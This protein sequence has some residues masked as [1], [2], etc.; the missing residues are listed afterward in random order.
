MFS[1]APTPAPAPDLSRGPAIRAEQIRLVYENTT[2]GVAVT[3]AVSS[4]LAFLEWPVIP[5]LVVLA[6]LAYMFLVASARFGLS[7]FYRHR[8]ASRTIPTWGLLFTIAAVLSG[9]GWG[10]AGIVLYPT[11]QLTHQVFLAFVLG[12]MMVGAASTLAAGAPD[13]ALFISLSGLPTALHFFAE[14]DDVH[15][16]MG[17]LGALY[18]LATLITAWHVHQTIASSLRLRFENHDLLAS[19]QLAKDRAEVLND[20]LLA[21]AA[22]RKRAAEAVEKSEKRLELAL[23]GADLGLWDWDLETGEIFWDEHWAAML[24]YELPELKPALS[25]WERLVH[26]EDRPARE[27]ALQEH[28]DGVRPFYESEQRMRT[29]SGEWKWIL[30]R[31][32]VVAR[33]AAGRPLRITG[34]NRDVT[35]HRRT[36]DALRQSHEALESRVQERTAKLHEAVALLRA[37]IAERQRGE[38]EREKMEAQLHNA[39]KIEAIG[40]L[41]RGIAHD[42]NNIL[43]SIIGFTALAQDELPADARAQ[44]HLHQVAKAGERA[45]DLVRRLL[46]FSRTGSESKRPV[47]VVP[48]VVETLELLRASIPTSIDLRHHID[49]DCGYVLA[50][51]ALIH[52]VVMNLCT[53][54]YQ[55]MQG[56][57]GCLEVTMAPVVLDPS[58]SPLPAG[59]YVKLTV[60]DTGPGIPAHL[61]NRVFEPFFT[62]KEVGH[63]TGLGLAV[64]HGVV[65]KCG[66]S[67]SFESTPGKGT[68]FYVYLPRTKAAPGPPKIVPGAVPGGCERILLVDDEENIATLAARILRDLGY[69]VESQ[70]SSLAALHRF[71]ADPRAFDLIISDYN[72]PKMTGAEFVGKVRDLRPDIP[73]ILISGLHDV[74]VAEAAKGRPPVESVK[75]PFSRAD[76]AHAVR[77]ALDRQLTPRG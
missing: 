37:E 3:I 47:E 8:L 55:A 4:V 73:A 7:Q 54:A 71:T 64:V 74:T 5:H 32:K 62:T 29:K 50:D 65:T 24:G 44:D 13:F 53:N 67:V 31:G 76:L 21:E 16:A 77:R 30:S 58:R 56:S 75:K 22:E 15:I 45:A 12:G 28:L 11:G 72:M 9:A 10:A 2:L 26:P 59:S 57:I 17:S 40:I 34:T 51:P 60:S 68:S 19:L 46:L 33:N 63:G 18:T 69:T 66:G 1:I 70:T 61:A 41:A 6:W 35:E 42:F 20:N 27:A 48:V 25:T 14:A 39:Q 23:F 36:Q 43:T 52:Q 49:P 38:E